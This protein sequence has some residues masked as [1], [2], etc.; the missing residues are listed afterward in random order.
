MLTR[1]GKIK[2]FPR[3]LCITEVFRPLFSSKSSFFWC[4]NR[5]YPLLRHSI[6]AGYRRPRRSA[7]YPATF[8]KVC[9][10]TRALSSGNSCAEFVRCSI[11]RCRK[12]AKMPKCRFTKYFSFLSTDCVD[13]FVDNG[14]IWL[15]TPWDKVYNL[16]SVA[17]ITTKL[18]LNNHALARCLRARRICLPVISAAKK[19]VHKSLSRTH[20][21]NEKRARFRRNVPF[22][23]ELH[24]PARWARL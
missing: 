5:L 19:I 13:N 16:P 9:A 3:P 20:V 14:G 1:R 10:M 12:Q 21:Q 17:G 18:T 11:K 7:F 15:S 8:C 2:I 6:L 23:S 22:V 24:Q 4:L